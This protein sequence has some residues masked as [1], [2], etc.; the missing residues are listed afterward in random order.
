MKSIVVLL[1]LTLGLGGCSYTVY[2]NPEPFPNLRDR[3]DLSIGIFIDDRQ[4]RQTYS[5]QSGLLNTWNIGI[6]TA[7]IV[8]AEKT[9]RRVFTHVEILKASSDFAE[10]PLTLLITLQNEVFKITGD[11]AAILHLHCKLIDKTGKVVY[12][13]TVYSQGGSK[14][15]TACLFSLGGMFGSMYGKKI[16]LKETSNEAFN[17]AFAI[18]ANDIINKV[19]FSIYQKR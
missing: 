2:L 15:E 18:L 19:D 12:E 11:L 9:F 14:M 3:I 4:V 16:L 6:G 8:G 10:K 13:N 5:Y 17:K 7:L 1:I